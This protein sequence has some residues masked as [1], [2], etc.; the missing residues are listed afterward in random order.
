MGAL[1]LAA[2]TIVGFT[3]ACGSPKKYK[4]LESSEIRVTMDLDKLD[5]KEETENYALVR[6][7]G[8]IYLTKYVE[9]ITGINVIRKYYDVR[10]KEFVGETFD[11]AWDNLVYINMKDVENI[12]DGDTLEV[13]NTLQDYN[14][15]EGKYGY[16]LLLPKDAII[17]LKSLVKTS[18][19]S[20]EQ[21][22]FFTS[23]SSDLQQFVDENFSYNNYYSA[24]SIVYDFSISEDGKVCFSE[25]DKKTSHYYLGKYTLKNERGEESIIIGRRVS[26][27]K[28]DSGYNL[29]YDIATGKIIDLE[30]LKDFKKNMTIDNSTFSIKSAQK[31]CLNNLKSSIKVDE[32]IKENSDEPTSEVTD[33]TDSDENNLEEELGNNSCFFCCQ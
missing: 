22:D 7:D 11:V 33:L 18:Y 25:N 2:T 4:S 10:T 27:N 21:L 20:D 30:G 19:P 3:S 29:I 14:Q 8:N 24:D 1:T 9:E 13:Q 15:M 28:N 6:M 23:N 16:G 32:N 17:P 26:K 31:L 12:Q 5:I